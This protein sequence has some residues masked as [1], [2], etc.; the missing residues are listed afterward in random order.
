MKPQALVT[1]GS[2]GIGRAICK[3]L[4]AQGF[5]V[6]FTY[7]SNSELA[8]S[9]EQEVSQSAKPGTT[10]SKIKGY[11]IDLSNTDSIEK[12]IEAIVSDF[13]Q[14]EV[15]VNNAGIAADGLALRFKAEDFDKLFATNVRG[16]FLITQALLR[17]MMKLRRGSIIFISSVIG[18][19]GNTGQAGYAAT[20]SALF[21]LTKSLAREFGSRSI[22]VNAVAPGFI[23]T[24]MTESL[25]AEN[26]EGILAQIPLGRLGEPEDVARVVAF[27]ASPASQYITGE[28]LAVNGG[29]YM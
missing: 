16:A 1:G 29:L 22:R 23:K 3:E 14:I 15:V 12:G 20:K 27:L 7:K 9:L 28:V 4:A 10:G 19:M 25:P 26:K 8:H 5:D 18:Q 13:S 24:D 2:R 6:A 21:G 17:P 11:C